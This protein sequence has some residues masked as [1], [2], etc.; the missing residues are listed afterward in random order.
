MLLFERRSK[1]FFLGFRF[2]RKRKF[3]EDITVCCKAYQNQ[4]TKPLPLQAPTP[5]QHLF[6][7]ETNSALRQCLGG[8]PN[9]SI[10]MREVQLHLLRNNHF[11]IY[12]PLLLHAG[13]IAFHCCRTHLSKVEKERVLPK[14]LHLLGVSMGKEDSFFWLNC[15]FCLLLLSKA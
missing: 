14:V 13:R 11:L 1:S 15:A 10:A 7:D 6:C 8:R 2:T 9:L 5:K 12:L 3:L 4:L